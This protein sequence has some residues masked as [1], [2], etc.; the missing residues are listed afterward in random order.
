[1]N[2]R[3]NEYIRLADELYSVYY[4]INLPT[5]ASSEYL[6]RSQQYYYTD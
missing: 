1:M 5:L 2:E 4:V 6:A 3:M